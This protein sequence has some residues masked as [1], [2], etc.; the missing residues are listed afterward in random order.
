MV[1]FLIVTLFILTFLMF[2]FNFKVVVRIAIE[3]LFAEYLVKCGITI[4][5]FFYFEDFKMHQGNGKGEND[6]DN[7]VFF[8]VLKLIDVKTMNVKLI[9]PFNNVA[10]SII[11]GAAYYV[12]FNSF[13]TFIKSRWKSAYITE[14]IISDLS[15]DAN[16]IAEGTF[17]LYGIEIT[18][19]LLKVL[20]NTIKKSIEG[21]RNKWIVTKTKL[22]K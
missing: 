4:R 7:S 2:P 6:S 3:R 22:K 18:I 8:K 19:I 5:G 13:M 11:G 20:T 9:L 12:A 10:W 14:E 21:I 17:R 15:A 16:L 1:V